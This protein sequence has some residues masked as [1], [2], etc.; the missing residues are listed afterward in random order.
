MDYHRLG[1]KFF[2]ATRVISAA[3]HLLL[4]C[5]VMSPLV[6]AQESVSQATGPLAVFDGQPIYEDQL[7]ANEKVQLQK[8]ML[9]VWMVKRRALQ[10]I[11][12]QKLVE[13]EAKKRGITE[14]AL[15][16]SEAD[17]N[18][19]DPTDDEIAAY[20]DA[21]KDSIK[22]PLD[23]LR[24]KIRQELKTQAIQKARVAYLQGLMQEAV[25]NGGLVFLMPPPKLEVPVDAARLRGDPKAP[26]TIVEFSDFS[27]PF[28][29]K[30]ENTMKELL[31][32]YPG[33]V[34]LGY[35]DYPLT[36][37][38]PRAEQAAEASRCAGEQGKYWEYHEL[39]FAN[40]D[41]QDRAGLIDQARAL[42]LDDKQ[43]EGCLSSGK[44]RREV[45][46]DAQLGMSG[47]V[48]GTPA[49][50]VNGNFLNGAQPAEVFEKIIDQLLSASKTAK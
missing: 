26:V 13:I 44:Y 40:P 30:A 34:R 10:T 8:M 4:V 9:Q 27:C 11:L 50:F 22:Q 19:Q 32:K 43:F 7:P 2:S 46:A 3:G 24:D 35:R 49:F 25:N 16:K 33:R 18:V 39:L 28:C 48:T 20:Y 42:K 41:K 17:A 21:R 23:E 37:L 45:Q 1:T 36:D 12:N 47:G 5:A 15:V 6:R 38:H 29:R 14:E 31:E